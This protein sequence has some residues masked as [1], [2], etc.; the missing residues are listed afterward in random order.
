MMGSYAIFTFATGMRRQGGLFLKM[1]ECLVLFLLGSE[2]LE[3]IC[4]DEFGVVGPT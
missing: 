2:K 4:Q 1:N 3:I